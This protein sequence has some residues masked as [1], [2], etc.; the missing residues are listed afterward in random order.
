MRLTI[1]SARA[2]IPSFVLCLL[3]AWLSLQPGTGR[4]ADGEDDVR[5]Q[6]GAELQTWQEQRAFFMEHWPQLQA[7]I[8]D[9]GAEAGIAWINNTFSD[10]LER[11]VI[12]AYANQG[13][14]YG[15]WA[16]RD[17][18][19]YIAVS[20]A[21]IAE[22]L[23]QADAAGDEETKN[24]R[25]NS[26]NVL[27]Y[28]LG[29]DLAFCWGDDFERERRHFERGLQAGEDCI[30]WRKELGNPP[31][32]LSMAY[33]LRGIHR[34]A[35]DDREG[36][37]SDF[38]EALNYC[39][40]QARA[41]GQPTTLEEGNTSIVFNH[42]MV[43][44]AKLVAGDESARAEYDKVRA[45]FAEYLKSDDEELKGDAEVYDPQFDAIERRFGLDK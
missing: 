20:D 10:D 21:G 1:N 25:V 18:D 4:A 33:W 45:M 17:L 8:E 44:L 28:N 3:A 32:T 31:F 36:A 16:G 11:R 29:A 6:P 41:D 39:E 23:R 43:A 13:L 34:M 12:Y 26:A 37:V 24:K 35:L 5:A 2:F 38:E 40:E 42:G 30:R 22:C 7:A 27:S 15:D 19:T 9:G 14:F